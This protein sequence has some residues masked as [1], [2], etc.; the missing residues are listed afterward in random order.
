MASDTDAP[1]LL[2]EQ[3]EKFRARAGVILERTKQTGSLHH[4]ILLF[5]AAH[6]HAKM[7]RFY[8]HRDT[9]RLQARHE[10]LGDLSGEIFLNLQTPRI[11]I[12]NPR[13]F[14]EANDFSVW[15]V[16]DVRAPDEWQQ[17]VL[18]Q[19]VKLNVFDQDDFARVGIEDRIVDNVIEVLPIALSE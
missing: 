15:N 7:F 13:H 10:R 6:H 11:N 5:D 16:S 2:F 12:D 19:R 9:R 14:G 4:R 17:M 1:Q 3:R 18:A 8:H